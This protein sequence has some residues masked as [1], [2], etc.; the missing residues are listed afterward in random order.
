MPRKARVKRR[1]GDNGKLPRYM[2]A[3][4]CSTGDS[5]FS[6]RNFLREHWESEETRRKAYFDNRAELMRRA[7]SSRSEDW[8]EGPGTRPQGFW[9]YEASEPFLPGETKLE[10]LQRLD[11]LTPA[12]KRHFEMEERP[13]A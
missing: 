5:I 13:D 1:Y 6:D 3:E 8:G 9:D 4:L 2:L 7:M 11:L 10:Y 12:E